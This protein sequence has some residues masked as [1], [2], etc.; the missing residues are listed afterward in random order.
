MTA[1]GR[2]GFLVGGLGVAGAALLASC[3]SSDGDAAGDGV[4]TSGAAPGAP[5]STSDALAA[6]AGL[7]LC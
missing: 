6:P 1:I 3:S 5:T 7:V 2:R 4:P